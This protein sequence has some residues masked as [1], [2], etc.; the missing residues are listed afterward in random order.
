MKQLALKT[1]D[2][3]VSDKAMSMVI[4]CYLRVYEDPEFR[5]KLKPPV[6]EEAKKMEKE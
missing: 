5:V 3:D 6:S 2:K 1:E 4:N